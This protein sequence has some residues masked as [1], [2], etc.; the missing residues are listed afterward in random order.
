MKSPVRM[1]IADIHGRIV[2]DARCH[3]TELLRPSMIAS[4]Q[5]EIMRELEPHLLPDCEDE[6]AFRFDTLRLYSKNNTPEDKQPYG[7][8]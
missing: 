7:I 2:V 8:R 5:R 1:S 3:P 4:S 6:E